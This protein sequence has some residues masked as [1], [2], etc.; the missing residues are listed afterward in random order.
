MFTGLEESAPKNNLKPFLL[1]QSSFK[2]LFIAESICFPITCKCN[3]ALIE[4]LDEI[5]LCNQSAKQII[6]RQSYERKY[7]IIHI[8]FLF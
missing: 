3:W 4:P 7:S 5:L 6:S 8:F 1:I 2:C